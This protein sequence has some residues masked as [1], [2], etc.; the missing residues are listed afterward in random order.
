M[1]FSFEAPQHTLKTRIA[2][3]ARIPLIF[4]GG[5][6]IVFGF[7]SVWIAEGVRLAGFADSGAMF[8]G[9]AFLAISAVCFIA[10]AM[11]HQLV[12][13]EADLSDEKAYQRISEEL[14]GAIK[15]ES[16]FDVPEDDC[17]QSM[18]M[19]LVE[20]GNAVSLRTQS[21]AEDDESPHEINMTMHMQR[22][23][24]GKGRRVVS[25]DVKDLGAIIPLDV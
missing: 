18:L 17:T 11:L 25:V 9:W 13:K 20:C 15:K 23:N 14:R 22:M 3:Q 10:Y 5:L 16:G 1:L 7:T 24:D 21:K 19:M 6:S 4:I 12:G 8:G 2:C